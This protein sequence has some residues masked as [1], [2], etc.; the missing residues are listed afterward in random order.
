MS[1][2]CIFLWMRKATDKQMLVLSHTVTSYQCAYILFF[3]SYL[4][5]IL[6]PL[7]R[8]MLNILQ[9]YKLFLTNSGPLHFGGSS[10]ASTLKIWDLICTCLRTFIEYKTKEWTFL[11]F[12]VKK[13]TLTLLKEIAGTVFFFCELKYKIF[14]NSLHIYLLIDTNKFIATA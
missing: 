1:G 7:P 8:I 12:S 11:P 6:I 9:Q 13:S 4:I 14:S 3:I 5:P 10:V 2:K